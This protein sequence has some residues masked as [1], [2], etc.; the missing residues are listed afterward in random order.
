MEVSRSLGGTI[1][2]VD[3][4]LR[5]SPI[6]YSENPLKWWDERRKL[7]PPLVKLVP[8]YLCMIRNSV[9]CERIFWFMGEVYEERL[10]CLS[11]EKASIFGYIAQNIDH[12]PPS[13]FYA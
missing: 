13:L 2:E 4:Y 11:V 12:V 10:N 9:P 5:E 6:D 1:H 7:N 8:R 3:A